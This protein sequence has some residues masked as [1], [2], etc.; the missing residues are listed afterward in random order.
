[1]KKCSE[2]FGMI[3]FCLAMAQHKI[4]KA[5]LLW[6]LTRVKLLVVRYFWNSLEIC[7]K[8][9]TKFLW[10][11]FSCSRRVVLNIIGLNIDNIFPDTMND[12]F[13]YLK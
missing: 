10:T 13:V 2:I 8:V 5:P 4:F 1:M 6:G 11:S 7:N 12:T 3:S 9:K